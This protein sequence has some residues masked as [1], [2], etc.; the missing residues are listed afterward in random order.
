[1]ILRHGRMLSEYKGENVAMREMRSHM[2]CLLYTSASDHGGAGGAYG[3]GKYP[4]RKGDAK[5]RKPCL[6]YTSRF[7]ESRY[8]LE[9]RECLLNGWSVHRPTDRSGQ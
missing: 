2:A 6:L 7:W 9:A 8:S 3:A 5:Q 4:D 1:M